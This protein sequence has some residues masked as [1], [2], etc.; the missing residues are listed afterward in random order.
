MEEKHVILIEKYLDNLLTE[1]EVKEFNELLIGDIDFK[2]L[3]NEQKRVREVLKAMEL[4]RP[5]KE[6]WDDYWENTY[7]RLERGLGWL[8]V[9]L[10]SLILI[11][12]ASIKFV[13]SL[14]VDTQ[15]PLI[16]KIG[17]VSLV[18]GFLVLLFSVIR[19]R[20]FTSNKDKYKEIRR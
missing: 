4:K 3:Y 10:G 17:V 13:E 16:I 19:E 9:F 8:A 15:T 18:F 6:I 1:K 2:N 12:F 7:N 11:G 5:G 14:Y 20:F